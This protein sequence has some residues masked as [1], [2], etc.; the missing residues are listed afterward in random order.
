MRNSSGPNR[1]LGLLHPAGKPATVEIRPSEKP[2]VLQGIDLGFGLGEK[3]LAATLTDANV[4]AALDGLEAITQILGHLG[5]LFLG[6]DGAV[7]EDLTVRIG[8][9][10]ALFSVTGT[11]LEGTVVINLDDLGLGRSRD[12]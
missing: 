4:D 3:F 9:L 10:E 5:A 8:G 12:R 1:E 7:E 11:E 2:V 6:V